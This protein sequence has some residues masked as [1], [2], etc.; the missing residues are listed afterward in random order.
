MPEFTLDPPTHLIDV[1]A[2]RSSERYYIPI[3]NLSYVVAKELLTCLAQDCPII[4]SQFHNEG[5]SGWIC[6][7]SEKE[8]D[9]AISWLQKAKQ[10]YP[11]LEYSA[12]NLTWSIRLEVVDQTSIQPWFI[13]LTS[14]RSE[15]MPRRNNGRTDW[16]RIGLPRVRIAKIQGILLTGLSDCPNINELR[17]WMSSR[18]GVDNLLAVTARTIHVG[19]F[20]VFT[21]MCKLAMTKDMSPDR[22]VYGLDGGMFGYQVVRAFA[23]RRNGD[24]AASKTASRQNPEPVVVIGSSK[25]PV[26]WPSMVSGWR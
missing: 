7:K 26:Y 8:F 25:L 20:D 4:D 5:K 24:G 16:I 11:R 12:A 14:V 9:K 17:L 6:L 1:P 19:M 15:K 10:H 22:I 23:E 3:R 18:L 21:V 2:G 13:K